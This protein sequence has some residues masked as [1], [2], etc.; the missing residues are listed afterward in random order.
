MPRS[1]LL[2]EWFLSIMNIISWVPALGITRLTLVLSPLITIR[3]DNEGHCACLVY[4][5]WLTDHGS[6]D[7]A[8]TR[9]DSDSFTNIYFNGFRDLLLFDVES[10]F[11]QGRSDLK[12]T[13]IPH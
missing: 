7:E 8:G 1:W 5:T 6:S 2:D 12:E 11:L 10:R 3:T 9:V 4:G 13:M